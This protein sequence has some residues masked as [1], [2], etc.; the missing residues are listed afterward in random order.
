MFGLD[1]ITASF[2]TAYDF[3]N[4]P[5]GLDNI[6]TVHD[7]CP[8]NPIT[9]AVFDGSI[10]GT[11]TGPAKRRIVIGRDR[12]PLV[13]KSRDFNV[14]STVSG[15]SLTRLNHKNTQIYS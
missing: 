1:T 5:A 3:Q 4:C 6:P 13:D 8:S 7:M 2:M 14:L 15:L 10:R 12:P 11:V 9:S